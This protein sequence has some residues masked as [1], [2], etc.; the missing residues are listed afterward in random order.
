MTWLKRLKKI[1][2]IHNCAYYKIETDNNG[3]L[4]V[5]QYRICDCGL[6]QKKFA[7]IWLD[8]LSENEL[9]QVKKDLT[10]MAWLDA[11]F[12]RFMEE[13]HFR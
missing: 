9:K 11:D 13:S 8:V 2:H 4:R 5:V 12:K 6:T 3:F 1:F 10:K 7:G